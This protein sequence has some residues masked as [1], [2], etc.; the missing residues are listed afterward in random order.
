MRSVRRGSKSGRT[1]SPRR[2][3]Q[4]WNLRSLCMNSTGP[5]LWWV[6]HFEI[7]LTGW[8]SRGERHEKQGECDMPF[9]QSLFSLPDVIVTQF[10]DPGHIL[11]RPLEGINAGWQPGTIK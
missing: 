6:P 7:A 8:R 11:S 4:R 5:C 1:P 9:N 2:V 10:L 3:R